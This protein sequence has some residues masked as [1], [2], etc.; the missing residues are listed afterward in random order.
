MGLA[1]LKDDGTKGFSKSNNLGNITNNIY[2]AN[3]NATQ[4][5]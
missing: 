2:L 3:E 5:R 4:E 1:Y